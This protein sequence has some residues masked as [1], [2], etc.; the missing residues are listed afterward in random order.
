M[1]ARPLPIRILA[2]ALCAGATAFA[3]AREP[4]APAAYFHIEP[5]RPVAELLPIALDDIATV[6]P[7][8]PAATFMFETDAEL[9][10]WRDMI[11][12]F[13]ALESASKL[14]LTAEPWNTAFPATLVT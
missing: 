1:H 11:G 6:P 2:L 14:L 13:G 10:S 3:H 12:M 9:L 5:V 4:A 7:I 8:L